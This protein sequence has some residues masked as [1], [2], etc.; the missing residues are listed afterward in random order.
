MSFRYS[1]QFFCLTIFGEKQ[2]KIGY[3]DLSGSAISYCEG[4]PL[5]L[6]VL[7]SNLR[8]RSKEAWKS[9]LTKLQNIPNT[10]IYDIKIKL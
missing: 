6:K 10:K 1:L 5:A 4:I 3:E 9:E 7:G 8:S 2:P